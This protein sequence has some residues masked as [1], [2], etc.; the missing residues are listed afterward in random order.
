MKM[1]SRGS[2]VSLE[3]FVVFRRGSVQSLVVL[4]LQAHLQL[5]VHLDL[6]GQLSRHRDELEVGVAG[7]HSGKPKERLFKVVA[8]LHRD[9][10]VL[11]VPLPVEDDGLVLDASVLDV[12]LVAGQDDR[13]AFADAEQFPNPVWHV[14]VGEPAGDVEHHDRAVGVDVVAFAEAA[15]PLLASYVPHVESDRSAVGVEH[16]RLEFNSEGEDILLLELAGQVPLD[17]GRLSGA[18]VADEDQLE[19]GHVLL[20]FGRDERFDLEDVYDL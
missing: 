6:W 13:N 8:R 14:V 18:T 2:G 9:V 7:Q 3:I 20:V 4:L 15:G 19:G 17:Q 1:I 16:E 5:C 12:D 10:V 11:E